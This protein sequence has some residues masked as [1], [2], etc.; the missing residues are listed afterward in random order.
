MPS[1]QQNR[2]G[3]LKLPG[4]TRLY[5]EYYV[6]MYG[7]FWFISQNVM[8][9]TTSKLFTC[10]HYGFCRPIQITGNSCYWQLTTTRLLLLGDVVA[11]LAGQQTYDSQVA[12][13]STSSASLR[14]GFVQATY[15]C[16]PVTK[17]HNLV[18][19]KGVTSLDGKI[20]AGLVE[21]NGSLPPG[22]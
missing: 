11:L 10:Y 2:P 5:D 13:S 12:G 6:Y 19:A 16:V 7:I 18:L 14:S 22:L 1:D 15:T 17:Q 8:A 21:S 20:T 4:P 3:Q 9:V